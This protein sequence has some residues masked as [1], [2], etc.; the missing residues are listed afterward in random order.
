MLSPKEKMKKI[1][2][3][4]LRNRRFHGL[5]FSKDKMIGPWT[6]DFYCPQLRY[7]IDIF[8]SSEPFDPDL[9]KKKEFYLAQGRITTHHVAADLTI[10]QADGAL[11]KVKEEICLLAGRARL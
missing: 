11:E 1:L 9:R 5:T 4:K 10:E 3:S 8:D 2:W 7:T 6:V